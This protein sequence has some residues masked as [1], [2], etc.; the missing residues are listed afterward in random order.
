MRAKIDDAGRLVVPKPIRERLKIGGGSAIDIV[1]Q[2]GVIEI[3]PAPAV[4]RVVDTPEG[5][6]ASIQGDVPPLT[7]AIV[8]ETLETI[9]R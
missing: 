4:I 5:P 2:D 3:R 6:V 8:R 9:R 7:D 1:E